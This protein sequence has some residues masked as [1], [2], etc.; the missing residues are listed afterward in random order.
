VVAFQYCVRQP[1]PPFKMAAVTKNRNYFSCQ[2]LLYYNSKWTQILTA[3]TWQWAQPNLLYFVI[4]YQNISN[5]YN[6]YK[7]VERK[8]SQKN[9]EYMLIHSLISIFSNSSHLEWRVGLSDTILKRTH[10]GTI[11]ARFS[12]IW[13]SGF[14]GED[15]NV[16][17]YQSM[18]TLH[19]PALHSKWLLLLKI[20]ITLVV[21][22]CFIT[23]QNELKF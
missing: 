3:A 23:I 8:I 12:L 5:L 15:L 6:R 21:N 20:E 7:L 14:R 13:F 18:P 11:P 2:F 17:W 16:I 10:P 22:F 1:C 19:S 9:P 4:F